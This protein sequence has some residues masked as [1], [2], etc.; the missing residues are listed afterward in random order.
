MVS[1]QV[2]GLAALDLAALR[3]IWRERFG[4]PPKLRSHDHLRRLL[5]WRMQ[6][7]MLGG[8]DQDLRRALMSRSAQASLPKLAI[9]TRVSR[10]WRGVRFEVEIGEEGVLFE[11]R[12][13]RSLS[14]VAREITGVRWNGP[15]FF[16]L[17]QGEAA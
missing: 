17:R 8:M 11:G 16:G 13:Y 12:I 9:G 2:R 4:S 15:R 3:I 10:D 6:A 1:E 7:E 5:A 14:Q